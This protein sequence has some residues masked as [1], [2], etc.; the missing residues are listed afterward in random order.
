MEAEL[1]VDDLIGRTISILHRTRY[2]I[3]GNSLVR[4]SHFSSSLNLLISGGG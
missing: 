4:Q 2:L 1:M 3:D